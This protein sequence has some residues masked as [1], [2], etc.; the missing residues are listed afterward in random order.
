[1]VRGKLRCLRAATLMVWRPPILP[2]E[3]FM[4][5][6]TTIAVRAARSAG[7]FLLRTGERLHE[8]RVEQKGPNDF[9][10]DADREAERRIVE[11]IHRSYP[12]H[13][14]L[15][16]EGGAQGD[17]TARWIIDPLDGTTNY[18]HAFPWFAV[19]IALEIQGRLE[20]GVIYDPTRNELFVAERGQGARLDDRR[21]RVSQHGKLAG[22]M[23]GT[24]FPFKS[25]DHLDAYTETFKAVSREG[26][27]VRRAGSAALDLAYVAA[28]RFDGFWE[29][30]LEKWD[31]AAGV[32]LIQEAGGAVTD[33]RGGD[34]FMATGNVVGGNLRVHQALLDTI[35]SHLGDDLRA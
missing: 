27:A 16:E 8:L 1:M 10:S 13:A 33:I 20:V 23:I 3:F 5:G 30:G 6:L 7:D 22:A 26:C 18:L 9:V 29:L 2:C 14:I 17:S 25:V 34:R 32:L 19:S 15:G 35:K 12:D 4:S 11:I 21:L 28:G 24:G 31:I